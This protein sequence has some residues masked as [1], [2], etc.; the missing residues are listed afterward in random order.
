VGG[1][2][3]VDHSDDLQLD[4]RRQYVE[5]PAAAAEQYGDLVDVYLV[6]NAARCAVYASITCTSRSPA[7]AFACAMALSIPSGT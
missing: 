6:Q 4:P 1:L 7:A 2:R 5:Q 3:C